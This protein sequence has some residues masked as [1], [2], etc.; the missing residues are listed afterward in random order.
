MK[1]C[2]LFLAGGVGTIMRHVLSGFIYQLLGLRF[3]Y[4]TLVINLLGCF[5]IGFLA[6]AAESRLLLSANMR[7]FLMVGLIGAFTTFSTFIFETV[8]LMKDGQML[9]AFTNV[10]L[11]VLI[12]CAVFYLGVLLGE[13]I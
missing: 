7:L 1:W 9:L 12:G 13:L 6:A 2:L 4:G 5:I 3:P 10:F 11:S 8:N